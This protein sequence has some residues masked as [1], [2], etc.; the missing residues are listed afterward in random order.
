VKRRA[1]D[2]IELLQ[3]RIDADPN[4]AKAHYQQA[5]LQL[6]TR[7]LYEFY[8]P[9]E[10]G[11]LDR[12]E[13]LLARAVALDP[14]DSAAHAKLGFTYHQL[15]RLEPALASFRTARKLDPKDATVD[16][17]VPLILVE[18]EREKEAQAELTA[19]A[20]RQKVPLAKLRKEIEK[21]GWV[22][23]ARTL[24]TNGFIH[25]RNYLWSEMSDEAERIRN[26]LERGRKR[27]VAKEELDECRA[28]QRELKSGF[29]ASRVPPALKALTAAASRYGIGDDPCRHLLM[30]KIPKQER[31]KLIKL[32]D[33]LAPRV[34]AWLDSFGG[35]DKMSNEAAHSC[36]S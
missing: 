22:A 3:K 18:L 6:A 31:A 10:A 28:F 7:D 17:Y 8:A 15:D 27:R 34:D 14:S 26:S 24:L 11:V 1:T 2:H 30:K 29:D 19:V 16:V 35:G 13:K 5:V 36:T 4:D 9:D 25:A 23:D 21:V 20:R 32:A 33:R 12:A